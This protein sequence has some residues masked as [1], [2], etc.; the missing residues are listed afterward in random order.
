MREIERRARIIIV[1][2]EICGQHGKRGLVCV[3]ARLPGE[4]RLL[5]IPVHIICV[6]AVLNIA[7]GA[8]CDTV[9]EISYFLWNVR[10][11]IEVC[12]REIICRNRR[13]N[14]KRNNKKYE[15]GGHRP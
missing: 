15:C 8:E 13:P 12:V 11:L 7:V 3:N 10:Q 1:A 4:R 14:G 9:R 6:V 2:I 5:M